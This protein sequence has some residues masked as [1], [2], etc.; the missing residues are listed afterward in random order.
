ML[1]LFYLVVSRLNM[2]MLQAPFPVA[3]GQDDTSAQTFELVEEDGWSTTC[4]LLRQPVSPV[5]PSDH[6]TRTF[7]PALPCTDGRN[8]VIFNVTARLGLLCPSSTSRLIDNIL[9]AIHMR[10]DC[11]ELL[12]QCEYIYVLATKTGLSTLPIPQTT[13]T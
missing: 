3:R 10:E 7:K 2:N 1:L 13:T 4:A 11:Q 12:E 5:V 6:W 8:N 9:Q